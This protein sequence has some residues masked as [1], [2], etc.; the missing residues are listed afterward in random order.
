[1]DL[2]TLDYWYGN[3]LSPLLFN[4]ESLGTETLDHWCSAS[5]LTPLIVAASWASP[6]EPASLD[7]DAAFGTP[8]L[9]MRIVPAAVGGAEA[10]GFHAALLEQYLA[11]GTLDPD[12]T[13]I[14]VF[15]GTKDG[16]PY[17]TLT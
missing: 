5:R 16:W 14:Y 7:S 13:G 10:F 9:T 4:S 8:L 3:T 6:I 15:A 12:I 11:T 1:M 17:F 2:G